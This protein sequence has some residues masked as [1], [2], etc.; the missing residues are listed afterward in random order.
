MT[1]VI[2]KFDVFHIPLFFW[3][4]AAL[5]SGGGSTTSIAKAPRTESQQESKL[6][7]LNLTHLAASNV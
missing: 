3:C 1:G 6:N 2:I 5:S 7:A 4:G